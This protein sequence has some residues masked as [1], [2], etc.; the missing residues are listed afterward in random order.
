MFMYF[1]SVVVTERKG[2]LMKLLGAFFYVISAIV[3]NS[4]SGVSDKFLIANPGREATC[5]YL[6]YL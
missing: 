6:N 1:V 2:M 3:I 5:L 4:I